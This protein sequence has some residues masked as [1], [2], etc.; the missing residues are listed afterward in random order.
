[1][2]LENPQTYYTATKHYSLNY[3]A[4]D[5]VIDAEVVI[6]GGGFTGINTALE[7]A[8]R[9]I[10]DVV[11][12]ES[13]QIGFGG[14]GRN[15]GH[16]MAGIGHELERIEKDVSGEGLKAILSISDL[17]AKIIQQRIEQYD[18][19]A[20][21]QSGYGYLGFNSRQG[22]LLRSWEKVY[23]EL[24]PN[25]EIEYLEGQ[26]LQDMVG[27]DY[28]Q[29]GLKHMGNGHIHSLNLLLGSAKAFCEQ[30]QGRVY[31]NTPALAVEYGDTISV[32]TARGEVRAKKL[33]WACGAFLDKLEPELYKS[34]INVYAFNSCTEPLTD[35]L[36]AKISPIRGAFSD[37]RPVLD[38]YRVTHDNRLLF[39]SAG[40]FLETSP[41]DLKAWN[42]AKMLKVF[43]YLK[44]INIDMAWGGPMECSTNLFPQVGAL[45]NQKNVFYIQGYSGFGVTPSHVIAQVMADGMYGGSEAWEALRSIPR[46]TI[47]GKER[48]RKTIV[49]LAKLHHQACGFANGRR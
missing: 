18:I 34:T 25:S 2:S 42:H 14:S 23:S 24:D 37:V 40:Y 26:A 32:R 3:P 5:E 39:G 49:S 10:K 27:S 38:Y 6:I 35:Q 30:H 12:L 15:G 16:V 1:M 20:N 19:Q 11:V 9:G 44:D 45:N 31:E 48:F 29:Y 22:K 46:T 4:L 41:G 8:E 47:Y 7:L 13:N 43:P 33:L 36:I 28:Y 21:Y 17:G